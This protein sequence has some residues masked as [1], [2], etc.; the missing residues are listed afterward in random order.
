[1]EEEHCGM[2][3]KNKKSGYKLETTSTMKMPFKRNELK[4]YHEKFEKYRS[5]F[6]HELIC[7]FWNPLKI[8]DSLT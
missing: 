2:W 1:M 7:L 5:E 6:S 8:F 3:K 4:Q